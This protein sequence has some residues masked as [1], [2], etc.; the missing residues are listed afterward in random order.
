MNLLELAPV[1]HGVS[2]RDILF[3]A[4]LNV[5]PSGCWLWIGT[6]TAP[7]GYGRFYDGSRVMVAHRYAYQR[8]FGPIPA[9][10]DLDHLCRN[11]S[12][13]NPLHLEAVTRGENVRRTIPHRT[14]TGKHD[15]PGRHGIAE[16]VRQVTN[17]SKRHS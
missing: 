15:R 11:R 3:L 10:H 13:V 12:C 9:G 17:V 14:Y 16:F 7:G 4:K 1:L 5:D 6:L 8:Q 2:K